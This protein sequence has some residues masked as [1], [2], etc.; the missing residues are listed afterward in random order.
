MNQISKMLRLILA[1]IILQLSANAQD[2]TRSSNYFLG[3][4]FGNSFT[5]TGDMKGYFFSV[6]L[7]KEQK[8]FSYVLDITTTLNDNI[9]KLYF[10]GYTPTGL[11][12]GSI[13]ASAGGIQL[14]GI[15]NYH[16]INVNK[17]KL[18]L[19]LGGGFRYQSS[20][21]PDG[22]SIFY[23]A[24]TGLSF[25]VIVF[26]TREPIRTFT[27]LPILQVGYEF[28]LNNKWRLGLQSTFQT[29][30]NGDTFLNYGL[31]TAYQI[32]L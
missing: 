14:T 2:I 22:Y 30:T 9:R 7:C 12:D 28:K 31:R 27:L 10:E 11:H 24:A 19:G 26:D 16:L 13:K 23:P 25:P 29:D 20:S 1:C 32:K 4:G 17:H 5:G 21:V 6:N 18:Q 8:R 3:V 15:V